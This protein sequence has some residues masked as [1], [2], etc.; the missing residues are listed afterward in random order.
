MASTK[1]PTGE[2]SICSFCNQV[3]QPEHLYVLKLKDGGTV[4]VHRNRPGTDCAAGYCAKFPDAVVNSVVVRDDG[5]CEH[6][7]A[8]RGRRQ[9]PRLGNAHERDWTAMPCSS[10]R[11]TEVSDTPPPTAKPNSGPGTPTKKRPDRQSAKGR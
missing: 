6:A 4:D 3:I 11:N 7:R 2:V 8:T 10:D 9:I 5:I 1:K